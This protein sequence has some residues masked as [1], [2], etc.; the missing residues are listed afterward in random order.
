MAYR[1]FQFLEFEVRGVRKVT[2]G[3]N[4]SLL[5][6]RVLVGLPKYSVTTALS[7][8]GYLEEGDPTNQAS[9]HQENYQS[10]SQRLFGR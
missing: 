5:G 2:T 3:I 6:V 8:S 7:R 4:Y 10:Q 9:K 1:S